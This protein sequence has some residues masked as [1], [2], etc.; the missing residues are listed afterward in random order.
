MECWNC[1][2]R[3]KQLYTI[4]IKIDG[5]NVNIMLC[6]DCKKSKKTIIK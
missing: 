3:M 2:S 1:L 4:V 6:A 5:K